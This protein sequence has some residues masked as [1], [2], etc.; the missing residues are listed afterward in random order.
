MVNQAEYEGSCD[1]FESLYEITNDTDSL[2]KERVKIL[3][4][5][6]NKLAFGKN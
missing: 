1:N 4:R 3:D 5:I 6:V 2:I